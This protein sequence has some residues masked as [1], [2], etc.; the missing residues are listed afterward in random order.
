MAGEITIWADKKSAS[1]ERSAWI[2]FGASSLLFATIE[3]GQSNSYSNRLDVA[4][5]ML[6][7]AMGAFATE[8]WILRP[9]V[10]R[11]NSARPYMGVETELHF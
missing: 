7:S 8:K 5:H 3:L 2:G 4:S 1:K 6:G 9:F 10:K 11:E